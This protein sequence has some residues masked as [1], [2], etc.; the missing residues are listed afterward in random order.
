M[1][2]T[3]LNRNPRLR[4]KSAGTVPP[5]FDLEQMEQRL[6][7][8]ANLYQ[9][10]PT[11]QEVTDGTKV[12]NAH[13]ST[14]LQGMFNQL[15]NLGD[16]LNS[17]FNGR[18]ADTPVPLVD[19]TLDDIVGGDIGDFFKFAA[20]NQGIAA[21]LNGAAPDSAKLKLGIETALS[22]FGLSG[23][24]ADKSTEFSPRPACQHQ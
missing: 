5:N 4:E 7:L 1:G 19:K 17:E 16:S 10:T 6:L 14:Q 20:G 21:I 11:G 18:F 24:V 23:T 2:R 13:I 22:A 8:S 9:P 12:I 15:G 3:K